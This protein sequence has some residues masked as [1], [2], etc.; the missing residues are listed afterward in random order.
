MTDNTQELDEIL[1]V[2]AYGEYSPH[3]TDERKTYTKLEAKQS[4][5]DWHNKQI[6]AVLD[7]LESH[8]FDIKQTIKVSQYPARSVY[9]PELIDAFNKVVSVE[10]IKAERNKLKER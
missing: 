3:W 1:T 9:E 6:E 2:F 10:R 4:I 8:A 5:L 7:R